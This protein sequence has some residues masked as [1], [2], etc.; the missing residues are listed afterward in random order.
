[1]VDRCAVAT[2]PRTERRDLLFSRRRT[3][4]PVSGLTQLRA[5]ALRAQRRSGETAVV[6]NDLGPGLYEDLVSAALV[7]RL[8]AVE[9]ALIQRSPLRPADAAIA[10]PSRSA[11]AARIGEHGGVRKRISVIRL[12][13]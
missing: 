2:H 3:E 12:R 5:A 1:M 10:L 8:S 6:T 7:D 13:T 11:N 4:R 9:E